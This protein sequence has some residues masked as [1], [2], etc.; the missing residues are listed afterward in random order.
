MNW[1]RLNW[2]ILWL[3]LM[4]TQSDSS[5]HE[6]YWL[7]RRKRNNIL[8]FIRVIFPNVVIL[9]DLPD[10]NW[11]TRVYFEKKTW[12]TGI[13]TYIFDFECRRISLTSDGARIAKDWFVSYLSNRRQFT[14]IGAINSED[15]PISC[16][17]P[18]G[19]VLGP[20]LFLIYINDF[21]NCTDTLNFCLFAD[22]SNLFFFAIRTS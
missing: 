4:R 6:E 19:S 15:L 2:T 22:D 9:T 12:S 17:V 5:K 3:P 21:S 11:I 8:L 20:L 10:Q 16:G 18:Q 13:A 1:G 14:S 7:E